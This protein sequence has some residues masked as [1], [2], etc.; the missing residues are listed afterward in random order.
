VR[1]AGILIGA[2]LAAWVGLWALRELASIA[3][4]RLAVAPP[5]DSARKPGFMPGPFDV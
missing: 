1:R 4:N 3:G 5:K 2:A